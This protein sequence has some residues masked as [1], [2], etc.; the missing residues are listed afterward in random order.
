[1]FTHTVA[2]SR[3]RS[4]GY[5]PR[6]DDSAS[7]SRRTGLS[8][9]CV[10]EV[11]SERFRPDHITARVGMTPLRSRV[12]DELIRRGGPTVPKHMWAWEPPTDVPREL[13]AQLDAIWSA[14]RGR[15]SLFRELAS[16][17]IVEIAIV[18]EHHGSELLLGWTLDRRHVEHAA[19]L[20]ATIDVDEYDYTEPK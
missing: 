15:A 6:M 3:Y 13:N 8:A 18:L 12:A 20:G 5:V 4:L 10:L 9:R 19:E 11:F 17:G 1:M 2:G 7:R 14:T 16:S